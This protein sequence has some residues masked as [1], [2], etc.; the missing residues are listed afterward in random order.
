MLVLYGSQTGCS[1]DVAE[2]VGRD[3]EDRYISSRVASMDEY[4]VSAL[5]N[6]PLV[7]FLCSTTGDGDVPDSML[8]FWRFL[9]MFERSRPNSSLQLK[10]FIPWLYRYH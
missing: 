4:D 8:M 3:A 1:K 2:R 10:L 7:I 5:P 6:E 9:Y